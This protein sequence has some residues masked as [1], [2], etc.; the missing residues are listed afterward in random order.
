MN[1]INRTKHA[2]HILAAL[3]IS[4]TA[5][6][7]GCKTNHPE[8]QEYADAEER[9]AEIREEQRRRYNR[10]EYS[11]LPGLAIEYQIFNNAFRAI[12]DEPLGY[13]ENYEERVFQEELEDPTKREEEERLEQEIEQEAAKEN[14]TTSNE[15]P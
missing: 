3:G 9:I 14:N 4:T 10:Y 8:S 2:R 6:V 15:T 13:Y 5:L 12:P 7:G 11:N 1:E